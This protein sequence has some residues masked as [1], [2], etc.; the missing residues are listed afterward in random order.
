MMRLDITLVGGL[1]ERISFQLTDKDG[2]VVDVQGYTWAGYYREEGGETEPMRVESGGADDFVVEFPAKTA[3]AGA[4]EIYQFDGAGDGELLLSGQVV[5]L[6]TLGAIRLEGG[7]ES[8]ALLRRFRVRLNEASEVLQVRALPCTAAE[9]VYR[10]GEELLAEA[11][12]T[13]LDLVNKAE[14]AGRKQVEAVKVEAAKVLVP[15]FAV[16]G[17]AEDMTEENV[18]YFVQD[19]E[20]GKWRRYVRVGESILTL[21]SQ[22]SPAGQLGESGNLVVTGSIPPPAKDELYGTG[23]P[24]YSKVAAVR[25]DG[26]NVTGHGVDGATADKAGVIKL[27]NDIWSNNEENGLV[28]KRARNNQAGLVM[29]QCAN[30]E[31][32]GE[33][34]PHDTPPTAPMVPTVARM[35]EELNDVRNLVN[36]KSFLVPIQNELSMV[37]ELAESNAVVS[38]GKNF[39]VYLDGYQEVWGT[40]SNS[41][42]E[43]LMVFN[44]LKFAPDVK[45]NAEGLDIQVSFQRQAT[46]YVSNWYGWITSWWVTEGVVYVRIGMPRQTTCYVRVSGWAEGTKFDETIEE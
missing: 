16:A 30:G 6:P 28:I 14:T 19:S 41:G 33:S 1:S 10:R 37:K 12:K 17:G 15:R 2:N 22:D 46:Q 27:S 32:Y 4:Y 25:G 42:G 18:V 21:D 44:T 5:V 40:I 23:T 24:V 9:L 13:G 45:F 11:A 3:G 34:L 43:A 36:D 8:E 7:D 29:V 38:R 39:R 35:N 31:M 20:T 26:T